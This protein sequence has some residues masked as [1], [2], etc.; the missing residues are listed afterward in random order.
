MDTLWSA[1]NH[2]SPDVGMIV[3]AKSSANS[4][5]APRA[6]WGNEVDALLTALDA[7]KGEGN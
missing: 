4:S 1:I 5:L 3:P 7:L 2:G 6:G